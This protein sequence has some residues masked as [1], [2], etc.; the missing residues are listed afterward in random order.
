MLLLAQLRM[1][2]IFLAASVHYRFML[3]LKSTG[4]LRSF[5][6]ELLPR[7]SA[8]PPFLYCIYLWWSES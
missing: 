5:L 6:T 4:T 3:R 1:L 7:Q 2:S 8:Q